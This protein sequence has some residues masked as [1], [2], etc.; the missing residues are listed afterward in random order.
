MKT[1]LLLLLISTMPTMSHG[2]CGTGC[3]EHAGVCACFGTP[4]I[5]PSVQPSDEKPR[6]N[7]IPSWQSGEVIASTQPNLA[8]VDRRADLERTNANAEGKRAAGLK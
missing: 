3:E 5:A 2:G 8:D 6:H 4:E 1:T 7:G